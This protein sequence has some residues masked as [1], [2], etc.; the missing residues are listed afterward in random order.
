LVELQWLCSVLEENPNFL[1]E[2][3]SSARQDLEGRMVQAAGEAT[4]GEEIGNAIRRLAKL[5]GVD[6]SVA[7]SPSESGENSTPQ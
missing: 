1:T 3:S 4:I 6:L 7:K 2:V 5:A